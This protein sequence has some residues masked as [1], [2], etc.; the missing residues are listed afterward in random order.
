MTSADLPPLHGLPL[1]VKDLSDTA[2]VRTTYGSRAFADYVPTE[3]G[4]SWGKLK[5]AGAI[6]LGK[7]TTPEFGLLG[8]TESPLTGV[9]NNP[10][11]SNPYRRRIKRR[12]RR[13][14]GGWP[15]LIR[16]GQ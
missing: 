10:W 8:V 6:L 15:G 7:T 2:G 9:T 1:S 3:D 16:L 5:A 11:G 12:R 4:L 14:G 13:S